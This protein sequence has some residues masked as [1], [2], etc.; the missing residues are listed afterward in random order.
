M[1]LCSSL[2]I[3][4]HCLSLGLDE[5]IYIYIYE[6]HLLLHANNSKDF[7]SLLYLCL[8][9]RMCKKMP[10]FSQYSAYNKRYVSFFFSY[11]CSFNF[12]IRYIW[13]ALTPSPCA[14]PHR[15]AFRLD[16]NVWGNTVRAELERAPSKQRFS[17]TSPKLHQ[18]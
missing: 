17:P 15:T 12:I 8:C 13:P 10:C 9:D 7:K 5:C 16:S 18:N 2:S 4:C 3:L 11:Y 6:H 1:Q 14:C